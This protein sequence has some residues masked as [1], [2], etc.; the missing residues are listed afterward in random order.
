MRPIINRKVSAVATRVKRSRFSDSPCESWLEWNLRCDL[1]VSY[2]LCHMFGFSEGICNHLSLAFPCNSKFLLIKFGQYWADVRASELLLVN[3]DG[4]VDGYDPEDEPPY[5]F[6]AYH[7]H[8]NCHVR[9]ETQATACFHTHQPWSTSMTCLTGEASRLQMVHQNSVRFYNQVAYWDGYE[10]LGN[11]HDEGDKIA[12]AM[13]DKRVLL[14]R[15]HGIIVWGPN[16]AEAWDDLYYFERAAELQLK[17][18]ASS[19]G[20]ISKLAVISDQIADATFRQN[21]NDPIRPRKRFA[22]QHFE[23]L[24]NHL[25]KT[26]PECFT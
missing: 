23:R 18:L 1:A 15:N 21:E 20:D 26:Q 5:E 17:A 9:G 13:G 8:R 22:E 7:I 3:M 10:G 4:T 6:S 19:G 12:R 24:K 16:A 11:A 14:A 2:R 25:Q